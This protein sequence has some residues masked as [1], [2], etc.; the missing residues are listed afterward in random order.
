MTHSD[1]QILF[2]EN[3]HRLS[4]QLIVS[5]SSIDDDKAMVFEFLSRCICRSEYVFYSQ[6]VKIHSFKQKLTDFIIWTKNIQPC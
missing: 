6:F 2:D 1:D 5:I 4:I 3:S